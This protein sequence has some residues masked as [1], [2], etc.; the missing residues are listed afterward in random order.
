MTDSME[1]ELNALWL[2]VEILTGIK[3]FCRETAPLTC[4]YYS[5]EANGEIEKL[6][7]L[8][9]RIV[10]QN[11]RLLEST[12]M[13]KLGIVNGMSPEECLWKVKMSHMCIS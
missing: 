8:N 13:Q 11:D 4:T 2:E 9:Q 3:F 10:N 12:M 5:D 1:E 6:Q 7:D